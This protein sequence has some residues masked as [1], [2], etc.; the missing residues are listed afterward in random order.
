MV[1][2]YMPDLLPITNG[3]C[4]VFHI[5]ELWVKMSSNLTELAVYIPS[6]IVDGNSGPGLVV[7]I[8]LSRTLMKQTDFCRLSSSAYASLPLLN[9]DL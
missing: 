5:P 7:G 4:A 1:T 6:S 9:L 3:E 2:K 8:R